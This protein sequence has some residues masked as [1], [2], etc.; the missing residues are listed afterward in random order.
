LKGNLFIILIIST[1][2]FALSYGMLA[3]T[4]ELFPY[5]VYNLAKQ[6]I[7]SELERNYPNKDA[8]IYDTNPLDLIK[9]SN[10][11]QALEKRDELIKFIWKEGTISKKTPDKITR[12]YVDMDYDD[13]SNLKQIDRLVVKMEYGVDSKIYHFIP[14]KSNNLALLYHQGHGGDFFLGKNTI[15]YFV[16]N[17]YNVLAFEMPL[18]GKNN[19]PIVE[20][21]FGKIRLINHNHLIFLETN[22]FTSMK[23]FVEPIAE[24]LNYLEQKH[25][26]EKFYMVGLSG[27]GL[28]ATIYP[29]LDERISESYSVA[30]SH[31]IYLEATE[32]RPG[33]YEYLNMNFYRIANYLEL[34]VLSSYGDERKFVQIFNEFDLCCYEGTWFKT[35]EDDVTKTVSNLSKGEFK[36]YLDSTHKEHKISENALNII[37]KSIENS[38]KIISKE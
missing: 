26:F 31:P 28:I 38:S 14:E 13:I 11:E 34:Y 1:S 7:F 18:Y 16:E 9:I 20:T 32:T 25:E 10:E 21:D 27:G 35:Y 30:G 29:A 12:N 33:H 6:V 4:F 5:E 22:N 19:N 17:G 24:V 8:H 2:L 37:S 36:I 15:K 23:F 3:G